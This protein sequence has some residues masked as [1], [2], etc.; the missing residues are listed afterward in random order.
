MCNPLALG[1]AA[2]AGTGALIN[3]SET[4]AT[5][6]RMTGARNAATR[7]E[8]DR[9]RVFQDKS[10]KMF[11]ESLNNFSPEQQAAALIGDQATA[12]SGYSANA[13]IAVG[14]VSSGNGPA[15]VKTAEDKSIA[16]AFA[17]GSAKD[18]ALGKLAG[19]DQ[20]AFGNNIKLN[21][22]GRELDLNTDFAKTS[23]GVNRLEQ[24]AAYNNAFRPNSG[25]GDILGFAGSVGA[26]YGGKGGSFGSLFKAPAAGGYDAV[27]TP[28][29][30]LTRGGPR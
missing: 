5:R 26:H 25:I 8:M 6:Q 4:N 24:D 14:S 23:A 10:G 19:W 13:P 22:S 18:A 3:A 27:G 21:T 11:D 16:D 30:Y 15:V 2:V 7:A 29:N 20:R 12:T 1:S 9:Q 17:R 28:L